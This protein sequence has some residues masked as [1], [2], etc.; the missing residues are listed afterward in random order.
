MP[1]QMPWYVEERLHALAVILLTER[2]DLMPVKPVHD[3]GV[4]FLVHI[5]SNGKPTGRSFGVELMALEKDAV[6]R[7]RSNTEVPYPVCL[8]A[9]RAEEGPDG[10]PFMHGL[11]NRPL[12]P[13]ARPS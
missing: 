13:A 5:C 10:P 4:D 2:D 6:R 9:L 7:P 1:K 12:P 3:Q 8:F 11:G